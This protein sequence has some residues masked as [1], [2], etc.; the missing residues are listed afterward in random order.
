MKKCTV[1]KIEKPSGEFHKNRKAPDGL[2]YKCKVCANNYGKNR[3]KNDPE[4]VE[5][6]KSKAKSYRKNNPDKAKLANRNWS[7]NNPDKRKEI[8]VRHRL[9]SLYGITVDQ[10]NQL[11]E[12]QNGCCAICGRH[13]SEFK[14][15]LAVDHDHKTGEVRGL[16]CFTCNRVLG[17]FYDDPVKFLRAADYLISKEI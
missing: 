3:W 13:Q 14:R 11:F 8:D 10:F 6:Q 7:L 9:K 2:A 1:C 15:S 17:M 12:K 5:K 4:F 16:L